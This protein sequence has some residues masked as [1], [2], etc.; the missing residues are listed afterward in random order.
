MYT[1]AFIGDFD[2]VIGVE[3]IGALLERGE[4]RTARFERF[5]SNYS[6]K[7]RNIVFDWV[8]DDFVQNGFWSDGTFILLHWTAFSAEQQRA[9]AKIL[10]TCQEGTFVISFTNPVP[11]TDFE[12][13]VHDSCVTSWGKA[14]FFFQEKVTP[15]KK[16]MV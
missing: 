8:E 7:I 9:I 1:A 4:K 11:G 6:E 14:D 13:L 5:Q 2:R 15:A 10:S 12:I 16:R 3:N